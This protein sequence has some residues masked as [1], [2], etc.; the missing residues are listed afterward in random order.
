MQI[1]IVQQSLYCAQKQLLPGLWF[2]QPII[3]VIPAVNHI[4]LIRLIVHKHIKLM[5][6]LLHLQ[7]R[8]FYRQWFNLKPFVFNDFEFP[9][10]LYRLY[11]ESFLK[12]G[13]AK[14]LFQS[15]FVFSD[16]TDD[17]VHRPVEGIR[18]IGSR[19]LRTVDHAAILYRQL[20]NH[21]ILKAFNHQTG[22][23]IAEKPLQFI[24]LCLNV[25]SCFVS[26][27]D[28]F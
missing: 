24:Q 1:R 4:D 8:F 20:N 23:W 11:R 28:L 22:R 14:A 13:A 15:R 2:N 12:G 21:L 7:N 3:S 5:A 19:I 16:L 27:A 26:Q 17:N 25:L 9:L 6:N 18:N 10:F